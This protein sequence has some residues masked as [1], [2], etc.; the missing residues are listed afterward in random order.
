MG[1]IES[2]ERWSW[3]S[4]GR[5]AALLALL[6]F[7]AHP[8]VALGLRSFVARDFGGYTLPLAQYHREI[9]WRGEWPLWNP[10][11]RCGLPFLAQWNTMTCY[12]PSLLYL[13]LP[14]PWSLNFFCLAHQFWA[15]LGMYFLAQRW[16]G[17]RLAAA[18]AGVGFAFN[19]VTVSA[20]NW[21]S[22]I[23]GLAWMPW[24]FWLVERT[25][26]VGRRAWLL[27]AGAGSMQML[28]GAPEVI[29]LTWLALGT[30]CLTQT[31]V[32][33]SGWRR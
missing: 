28:S 2:T 14:L 31:A 24:V 9:F 23:A 29:L 17:N 27:A 25:W 16:T 1:K 13:L 7:A 12:P 20:L 6:T 4:P 22:I 33:R 11:T 30:L 15:G 26:R 8:D 10:F 18:V 32:E 21:S 19:G 5:F 3:L